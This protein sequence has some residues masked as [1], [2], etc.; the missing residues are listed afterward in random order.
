[1]NWDVFFEFS[2]F[3]IQVHWATAVVAFVLGLVIFAGKKGN[4]LHK[5]LGWAYVVLMFVT[6][7]SAIFIRS[8]PEQSGTPTLFGY[9]P[10]HIFVPVTFFGVGGA[11]VAIRRKQVQAHRSGMVGTFIGALVIAG[12]FT[13][14]PDRR[15]YEFF[16]SQ[17]QYPDARTTQT[18]VTAHGCPDHA[19][20]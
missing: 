10:I 16:F 9:S 7:T 17:V 4:R 13:F 15:M 5:T 18:L 6:A 1:M 12:L 2:P 19:A 14:L 20:V 3:E 8:F 11:I